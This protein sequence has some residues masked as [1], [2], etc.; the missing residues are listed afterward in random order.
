[1]DLSVSGARL[2][3]E[4][5]PE[6]GQRLRIGGEEAAHA[7]A[8]R[9]A[10]GDPVVLVDG[11][12]AE[13]YGRIERIGRGTFDVLVE[14]VH[15]APENPTPPIHLL[16]AAVRAERLAWVAEKATELGVARLTILQSERTQ[17]FRAREA[18][19]P[20]LERVVRE[21]AKQ[22]ECAR[23]PSIAGPLSFAEAIRR[24][25]S[26]HRLLLDPRGES[27]PLRLEPGSA[28]LLVGPEGGWSDAEQAE[29][30]G[31][32]WTATSLAAGKLRAETAAIGAL[33]LALAAFAR[34]PH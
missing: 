32:G 34:N 30:L 20:R 19:V 27:F 9:L 8:R 24:E 29:A 12:G 18:V 22:A 14:A 13:A 21:A 11:G 2:I 23:W 7:R 16:V 15:A 10:A 31:A 33:V 1:V 17:R 6:S 4:R 3:V 26:R 5:L 25:H 28:A